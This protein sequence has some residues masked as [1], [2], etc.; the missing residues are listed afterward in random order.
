LCP[1]V[2]CRTR[3]VA[4]A[5]RCFSVGGN[6]TL[7]GDGDLSWAV[8]L[9]LLETERNI[10]QGL[11]DDVHPDVVDVQFIRPASQDDHQFFDNPDRTRGPQTRPVPDAETQDD[12]RLETWASALIALAVLVS[13]A[14]AFV[15]GRRRRRNAYSQ[16]SFD[17]IQRQNIT[18][19]TSWSPDQQE[20]MDTSSWRQTSRQRAGDD[21]GPF[22]PEDR[23]GS[24]PS[25][26]NSGTDPLGTN[27]DHSQP[28]V[29]HDSSDVDSYSTDP[30]I[31]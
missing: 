3:L 7:Y 8:P 19:A 5:S 17:P 11:L 20:R 26:A 1:S 9:A 30:H 24:F 13:L 22:F 31:V 27:S 12:D 6:Y 10:N 25:L 14:V 21:E 28:E 18:A 29:Y 23:T 2:Q 4:G 15:L 16:A